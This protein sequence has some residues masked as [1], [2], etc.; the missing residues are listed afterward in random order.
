MTEIT[1]KDAVKVPFKDLAIKD[2]FWDDA[3]NLCRKM[4]P[5]EAR[6]C[7]GDRNLYIFNVDEQVRKCDA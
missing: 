1:L 3:G 4:S 5:T 6:F 7:D 2:Y